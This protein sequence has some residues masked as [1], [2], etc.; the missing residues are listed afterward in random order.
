MMSIHSLMSAEAAPLFYDPAFRRMLETHL[1]LLR[2]HPTTQVNM[3]S[4]L[5]SYRYRGDLYGFLTKAGVSKDL[6]WLVMRLIDLNSPTE[7][8]DKVTQ[9]LIPADAFINQIMNSYRTIEKKMT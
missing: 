4:P 2:T 8:D 7:F 1:P 6:H 9:I 3:V 5:M